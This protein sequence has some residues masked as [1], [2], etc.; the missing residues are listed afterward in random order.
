MAPS[1]KL[2]WEPPWWRVPTGTTGQRRKPPWTRGGLMVSP[3]SKGEGEKARCASTAT[4]SFLTCSSLTADVVD[5]CV[6]PRRWLS[7][8]LFDA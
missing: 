7:P 4:G 3:A 5:D 8:F 2:R 6:R 1:V